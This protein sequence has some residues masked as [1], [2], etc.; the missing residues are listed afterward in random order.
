MD[1]KISPKRAGED[2]T[3]QKKK[4]NYCCEFFKG[5]KK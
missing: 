5:V 1:R 2:L 4:L 3:F